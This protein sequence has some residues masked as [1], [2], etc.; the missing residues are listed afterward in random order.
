MCLLAARARSSSSYSNISG[1]TA[2]ERATSTR[3]SRSSPSTYSSNTASAFVILRGVSRA[4][5]PSRAPAS[6]AASYVSCSV[7]TTGSIVGKPSSGRRNVSDGRSP[8]VSTMPAG[9]G[10]SLDACAN[11]AA[12]STSARSPG[13][14]STAPSS[15][16]SIRFGSV[17]AAT[18]RCSASRPSSSASPAMISPSH[19]AATWPTVGAISRSISGSA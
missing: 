7:S 8:P 17:I 5:T 10:S 6:V 12:S 4:I 9:E 16:R 3:E 19:A 2:S 15:M 18:V 14:I 13:V 11:S 1:V